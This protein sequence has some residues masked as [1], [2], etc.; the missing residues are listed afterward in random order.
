V[1]EDPKF[2]TDGVRG[3]ANA[4]L[5][6]YFAFRL[7]RTAGHVIGA[8][9]SDRRMVVGRDTRIS[10]DM[11]EAAL[12][13][14]MLSVGVDVIPVEVLPTP[15]V[16]YLTRQAEA[17]AGAVISASHNPMPDN[18]IKFF[19]ADGRKLADEIETEIENHIDRFDE[20]PSPTGAGVG[21]LISPSALID[22]YVQHVIRTAGD[23]LAGMK[24]V[25]DCANGAAFALAPRIFEAL[26]AEV[27]AIHCSPNGTNINDDCGALHPA[28]M[29]RVV[30]E[31][32][33]D[34][35]ISFDGDADRAIF[36]DEHG[37]TVD[38]DRVM[39]ICALAWRGTEHLPGN[40]VVSTVMSNMGLEIALRQAGVT[41]HRAPV[42]DRHVADRMRETGA[43]VGGEKSGHILFAR[44]GVTGDGLVTALQVAALMRDSARPLSELAAA[45][46]EL[47]QKLV[48][49]PVYRRRG[50]RT[51]P[52]LWEAVRQGEYE[53]GD[54]GRILV[55]ASGTER[56]IRVMAEGP[57][58]AQLD[59]I[60]GQIAGVIEGKMGETA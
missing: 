34:L 25:L 24:V 41:L 60:V 49:V 53:L 29:Q 56:I 14:G 37:H 26:G 46:P 3:R 44:H 18:G 9:R 11:L 13:S 35:G 16:S 54:H 45:I 30:A 39:G 42:G 12:I 15:G 5:S 4:D 21:R 36:A 55:R 40:Q 57:D 47:P 38:G 8:G 50:W 27:T 59:R 51:Q 52:E 1:T 20:F 28:E 19:G 23:R 2:G 32:S 17:V 43:A 7:G 10:G 22:D 31:R 6:A 48:N 33:A 58:Q